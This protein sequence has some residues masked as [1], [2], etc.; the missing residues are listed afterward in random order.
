M[1]KL[2]QKEENKEQFLRG[3]ADYLG[4]TLKEQ[5]QQIIDIATQVSKTFSAL[6]DKILN[7]PIVLEYGQYSSNL[8]IQNKKEETEMKGI[9]KRKDGR[10]IIRKQLNGILITKY[11]RTLEEARKIYV[12]IKRGKIKPKKKEKTQTIDNRYINIKDYSIKWLET[13][14]K[15][16]LKP[17]NYSSAKSFINRFAKELGKRRLKEITTEEIQIFFNNIERSITKQK[18]YIYVNA[19]FQTAC[20]TGLISRNP[21]K[22]VVKDK[23][24]KCKSDMYVYDEQVKI[25]N[26]ITGSDIEHEI[27]TYLMCGCRPSELPQKEQFDF[28]KNII[29]IYGTKNENAKHRIVEIS[30]EFANY[31][32]TY[33]KTREMQP[34]QYVS[35]KFRDICENLNIEKASIYR[36]RHTFASNH[37]ILRTQPKYVQEW[38]GHSSISITLD[39]Y[40]DIDK[41]A[42]KEK[43]LK[44]YN[45]FYYIP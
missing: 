40:T 39:T 9:S 43:I 37:F 33:L 5:H 19:M 31:M 41:T 6:Q 26:K 36:L 22:S 38:L 17:K 34:Q 44:L 13:Y 28:E 2:L 23:K 15:P 21:V 25:I 1:K 7:G 35:K 18:I 27:L 3:Y 11:A 29:N 8:L 10:Y 12:D 32:Q 24:V 45:N 42:T 30:K 14:K 20:D 4:K 16:F